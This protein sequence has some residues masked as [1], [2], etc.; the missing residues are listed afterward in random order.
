MGVTRH[1]SLSY[2][3]TFAEREPLWKR[4]DLCKKDVSLTKLHK[5]PRFHDVVTLF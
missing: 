4:W 2:D 5:F 3:L 1:L